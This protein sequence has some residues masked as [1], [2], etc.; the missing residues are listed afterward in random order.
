MATRYQGTSTARGDLLPIASA[1]AETYGEGDGSLYVGAKAASI[2]P[3]S[4]GSESVAVPNASFYQHSDTAAQAFSFKRNPG[5]AFAQ[6][7]PASYTTLD[8]NCQDVGMEHVYDMSASLVKN[9]LAYGGMAA[10][11]QAHLQQS[12]SYMLQGL[13]K[14]VADAVATT[15]PW[16]ATVVDASGAQ[17]S[18]VST[19]IFALHIT[20]A[21]IN[22]DLP[23]D[24][25]LMSWKAYQYLAANTTLNDR[26]GG[27]PGQGRHNPEGVLGALAT[28]GI[29]NLYVGST[30]K[31]GAY[32]TLFN[33]GGGSADVDAGSIVM[34]V[35]RGEDSDENGMS[36][37]TR[38]IDA[39][40]KAVVAYT[41]AD[42]QL[43]T[44][45][46]VQIHSVY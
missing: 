37:Y 43:V 17:W 24:S 6:S 7:D 30:A 40:R 46:G 19:D 10:V 2:L 22:V 12:V 13:D 33:R 31:Y 38:D 34:G 15:N 16:D 14:V 8:F 36:V 18:T 45:N 1:F 32:V 29:T 20:Q 4:L 11:E 35:V 26:Y 25:I 9:Q 5:S 28:A 3:L 39:R 42:V 44:A 27:Q 21:L 41:H 23:M